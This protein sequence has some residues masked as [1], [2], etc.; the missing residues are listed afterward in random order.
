MCAAMCLHY[1]LIPDAVELELLGYAIKLFY[2]NNN[3]A[4]QTLKAFKSGHIEK[5]LLT[6]MNIPLVNLEN[7]ACPKVNG[8]LQLSLRPIPDCGHHLQSHPLP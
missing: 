1:H 2:N 5:E 4:H 6:R 7:Y 3:T 8:L